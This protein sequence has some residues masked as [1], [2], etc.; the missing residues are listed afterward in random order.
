[1]SE[2][3]LSRMEMGARLARALE[4][5]S[6][7]VR[8]AFKVDVRDEQTAAMAQR[9]AEKEYQVKGRVEAGTVL[10]DVYELRSK[11]R[12]VYV[13]GGFAWKEEAIARARDM[14]L[15]RVVVGFGKAR[16]CLGMAAR[17]GM[18]LPQRGVD[19]PGAG[20]TV[21]TRDD[22]HG[23]LIVSRRDRSHHAKPPR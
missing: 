20:G 8:R 3:P 12:P 2:L 7:K 10:W 16:A 4:A 21:Y 5:E 13:I 17:G 1:M 11:G 23:G 22:G 14:L 18:L 9:R 6:L 15:G 19:T